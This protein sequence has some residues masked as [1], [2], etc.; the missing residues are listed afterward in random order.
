M[1]APAR[2]NRGAGLGD[3]DEAG[4]EEEDG[5][6]N[7]R[8]Q[9]GS[10][11][12]QHGREDWSTAWHQI[13][14]RRWRASCRSGSV[15]EGVEAVLA[16][17]AFAVKRSNIKTGK[18]ITIVPCATCDLLARDASLNRALPCGLVHRRVVGRSSRHPHK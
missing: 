1:G 3:D 6:K 13:P 7:K 4:M 17:S 11:A 9:A 2:H 8:R 5:E 18:K 14:D 10:A 15:L 16:G 12:G